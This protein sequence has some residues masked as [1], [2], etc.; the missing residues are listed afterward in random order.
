MTQSTL[1]KIIL[2]VLIVVVVI[3][4]SLMSPYF[5]TF[6]NIFTLLQEASF[7]GIAAVGVTFVMIAAGLDLSIGSATALTAM[8][9]INF[10]EYTSIPVLMFLPLSLL[11]G[12]FV[13]FFNGF[14]INRLKLPDF[15]VTLS[16]KGVFSGLALVIAV[17]EDGFVSN[18]F[19][20][21]ETYL[22]FSGKLG[23][24]SY[25]TIAFIIVA[26]SGHILLKWTKFGTYVYAT[27]AN[28]T[29]AEL[30]GVNV[31]RVKYG[32][33]ILAGVC[34]SITAIFQSSRMMTAMPE[35][36]IGTELD[37]IAAIV[38]GGTA[39]RGGR[40]DISGTVMGVLFLTII[41]NGIFKLHVTPAIQQV[42]IGV[43]IISA[44]VFDEWYRTYS[45]KRQTKASQEE[46]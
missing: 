8:V 2:L 22:W 37:I 13:G 15:I 40:G 21:N 12:A 46:S 41:K 6:K 5:L 31:Q 17:K 16:S 26:V 42:I 19:I 23:P 27:G 7:L 10:L 36:G 4:F 33:Y 24:L 29:A 14:V 18:V 9:C 35:M 44:V 20:D 3:F 28:R 1:R 30:S 38:I 43:I 11:A 32:V 39:F 34:A 25:V 45:A